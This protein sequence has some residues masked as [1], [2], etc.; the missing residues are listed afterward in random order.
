MKPIVRVG[1]VSLGCPK[2]QI[3][4]EVMLGTLSTSGFEITANENEADLLIVNTCGFIDQA[5]AE[6]IDTLVELGALKET[7]R[8]KFLLA[9]GCLAQRYGENLLKELPELDGVVGVGDFPK[10]AEVCRQLLSNKDSRPR[11]TDTPT[12]L[13]NEETP[14]VRTTP[15]HWAYVKV[16]EGCNYRCSFC[17]I[18]SFR[19]DLVSRTPDSVVREVERLAE[20]GVREVNLIAQSLTS[21]G[22]ERRERGGLVALLKKLA[23]IDGIEWIRLFYTYPTDFTE[24]LIELIASEEKICKYVDLPLQHIDDRILREMHRKGSSEEIRR[25]IDRLRRRI[26]GLTLRTTFIVGFPGEDETAFQSLHT[27]VEEVG[28]DR[29]GVFTYSPEEGTPAFVLGDTVPN[30][31]K[32]QRRDRLLK[33]QARLS[34]KR[35]RGMIGKRVEVRVDG[36]SSETDLLLEGRTQGQAPE[37]DGVI[38]ISDVGIFPPP[39]PGDLVTLEVTAAH[40]YDLVG[41]VIERSP[42]RVNVAGDIRSGVHLLP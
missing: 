14:R 7:G 12:F 13:Y 38:Y 40:T 42:D 41:R 28:F 27:F 36:P 32:A 4:A 5:K 33:L 9:A 11:L 22:W 29:L 21:Y 37:V 23:R 26:P 3:D 15:R 20:D 10:I 30:H 39:R 16:S 34:R 18:P 6:S 31:V 35:N 2:N 1:L 17:A 24:P 19:G 8:L 25:L